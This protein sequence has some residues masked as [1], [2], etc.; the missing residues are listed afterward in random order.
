MKETKR[1]Y[2]PLYSFFD[3][4]GIKKHLEAMS[5][6]GWLLEN[7]GPW[8]WQYRRIEPQRLQFTVTYFPKATQFDPQ[9]AEG[10]ETFREFCS[11]AG[12][13]LAADSAQVQVFYNEQEHP[14]PI[15]TD[16]RADYENIYRSIT[17]SSIRSYWL[18]L[19]LCL[20]QV[21]MA[22][23]RVMQD[24]IGQLSSP[25]SLNSLFGFFPL[26]LV[27]S[28]ELI[29]FYLW[30]GRAEAALELG[31]PLPELRSA[32][33]LSIL[34]LIL[35]GA[36]ILILLFLTRITSRGVTLAM[37]FML[38]YG[39]LMIFLTNS[40]RR[41]LQ[42]MQARPLVNKLV[43]FG[44]LIL[45]TV[46][47]MAGLFTVIISSS[48]RF[49]DPNAA[50]TYE[51]RGHTW[52]VYHDTLP[53]TVQDL[54]ENDY[55]QWST[56]LIVDSSPLL[57]HMQASQRPRMDAL[58]E[59]DLEYEL[60]IVKAGFLYDLCKQDYIDWLE[61]DNDKLPQEYWD[62][63]RSVDSAPWRATEVYQR[64]GSGEPIN[65]FLVCWPDRIAEVDFDWDWTI[66]E[67]MM[68]TAAEKLMNA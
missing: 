6:K 44:V 41:T 13:I 30:K 68:F 32:R 58:E 29:R 31:E 43:T 7:I 53:L 37:V 19:V 11:D 22:I 4:S 59:P 65:Q 57:T 34:I 46:G 55:D 66:T 9:P 3:R 51:Y 33:I 42:K 39:V 67:E 47:M 5:E 27:T 56:Q 54:V 16:P 60:V 23:W 24:P 38:L 62:E 14:V 1:E 40:I 20:F 21:G 15:E 61:R 48:R 8:C 28:V 25:L 50:E 26:A 10:L 18:L 36:E 35:S 64:Y 45:L 17:R 12:W 52:N 49:A 63:Y 2:L